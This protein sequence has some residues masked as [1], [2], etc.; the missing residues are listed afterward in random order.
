MRGLYDS[1]YPA[2]STYI[3]IHHVSRVRVIEEIPVPKNSIAKHFLS[4]FVGPI[5]RKMTQGC[6]ISYTQNCKADELFWMV[7][8]KTRHQEGSAAKQVRVSYFMQN[9]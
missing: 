2:H 4:N 6:L 8:G 7:I 3:A 1:A 9:D 5:H